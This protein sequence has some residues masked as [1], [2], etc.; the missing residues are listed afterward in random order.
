MPEISSSAELAVPKLVVPDTKLSAPPVAVVNTFST[1]SAYTQMS[2]TISA[3]TNVTTPDIG[4]LDMPK[5]DTH[6]G[7]DVASIEPLDE[8]T[9]SSTR[10]PLSSDTS[11]TTRAETN[12][13]LGITHTLAM[14]SFPSAFSSE[15]ASPSSEQQP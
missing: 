13:T 5:V 9:D 1:D 11:A 14:R 8:E 6:D 15:A 3:G 7:S 12:K 4:T 10:R 2:D